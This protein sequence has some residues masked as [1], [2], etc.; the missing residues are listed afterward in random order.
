VV[1]YLLQTRLPSPVEMESGA[2]GAA[3]QVG[4]HGEMQPVG[5]ANPDG[6]RAGRENAAELVDLDPD[7]P[8]PGRD[9]SEKRVDPQSSILLDFEVVGLQVELDAIE[10]VAG[11]LVEHVMD[12]LL[13]E[14]EDDLRA[15]RQGRGEIGVAIDEHL[16]LVVQGV[17]GRAER[18]QARLLAGLLLPEGAAIQQPRQEDCGRQHAC[19]G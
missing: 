19:A 18:C 15:F 3:L 17:A 6:W 2:P 7:L 4:G 16:E 1:L 12:D 13:G 5:S 14:S 9:F 8:F 10:V 11:D